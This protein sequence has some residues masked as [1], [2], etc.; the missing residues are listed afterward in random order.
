MPCFVFSTAL[1]F[2]LKDEWEGNVVVDIRMDCAYHRQL[3][4]APK[5]SRVLCSVDFDGLIVAIAATAQLS[6]RLRRGVKFTKCS[7]RLSGWPV[8]RVDVVRA[9]VTPEHLGPRLALTAHP[10]VES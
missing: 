3:A 6:N 1:K 9:M 8:W 5:M 4:H 2:R 7:M 10:R